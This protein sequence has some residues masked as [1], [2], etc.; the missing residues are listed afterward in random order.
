SKLFLLKNV[1]SLILILGFVF[2]GGEFPYLPQQV[3]LLNLL[4][5]GI[6]ALVITLSK[7]RSTAAT[8]SPFLRE[9][10]SF[11]L[12]SGLVIGVAGLLLC[13]WAG[14]VGRGAEGVGR[15]APLS[16]LVPLTGKDRLPLSLTGADLHRPLLLSALVLLGITALLRALTD[17]EEKPLV[18]DRRF[19][20]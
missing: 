16:A 13:L 3:T 10:G 8:K 14:W 5:I 9:V 15:G 2:L 11:V 4:T 19:R 1:Y 18:G 17:G 7:E 12:R 6:P 20:W